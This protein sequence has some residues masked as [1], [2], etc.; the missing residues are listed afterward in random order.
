MT[1]AWSKDLET[2]IEIIDKQHKRI[3]EYVNELEVAHKT[4]DRAL[5][6]NVLAD[7]IDYTLSHF[8]FEES[9]QEEAHYAHVASH[10][11]VHELFTKKISEYKAKFDKGEDV[12]EELH[13]MLT[14]WLINHIKS[15]DADYVSAVKHNMDK[16]IKEK[17]KSGGGWLSRFFGKK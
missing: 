2:G 4:N 15:D 9:L 12:T 3:V 13:H 14:K 5:T 16:V 8:A 6:G 7:C 17:E 11:K 1:I 10:K